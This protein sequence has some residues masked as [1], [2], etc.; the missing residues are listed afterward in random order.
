MNS[1]ASEAN[2][3]KDELGIWRV[4]MPHVRKNHSASVCAAVLLT[5]VNGWSQNQGGA[6]N[7]PSTS[8][9][10]AQVSAQASV[11]KQSITIVG[12]ND[13]N[14]ALSVVAPAGAPL[15]LVLLVKEPPAGHSSGEL[16]TMPFASQG[17][18][19]PAIARAK[20]RTSGSQESGEWVEVPLDKPGKIAFSLEFDRLRSGKTYKGQIFLTSGNLV[21]HWD[22]TVTT[23]GRGI[24]AVD[25]LGTL[26][27][28]TCL[29]SSQIGSFSFTL[30]DKSEG[31]P[32][33]HVH[34]RFEPSA[35]ANSKA[36]TSNFTF[37][38]FSFWE[39]KT[40]I[41]L[42]QAQSGGEA[43]GGG[44]TLT[45]AR[46]FTAQIGPLSPGEY[47]G[48]LHFS[49]DGVADDA[50]DGKLSL[51]IQVR[52]PWGYPV[53]VLLLG[54]VIGWFSS[55]YVVGKRKARDM[56]RQVEDLRKRADYLARPSTP[57]GGWEFPSEA[58]SLG[59]ARIGVDLNRVKKLTAS[60]LQVLVH[61]GEI[62]QLRQA[63]EQRLEA[64]KSLHAVRLR[65]QRIADGR[66]AAQQGIGRLLRSATDLLDGPA[67]GTQEQASMATL[68]TGLE[69]WA[70]ADTFAATYK[71]AVLDR[72]RDNICP[73]KQEIDAVPPGPLS[74]QLQALFK[75]LP[76]EAA[77]GNQTAINELTDSDRRIAR[78]ALLWRE[79]R[80]EWISKLVDAYAA[81][82]AI[83]D[84]FDTVD[85]LVWEV[86]KKEKSQL[87]LE[88]DSV[89]QNNP[90]TYE[91]LEIYLACH[92]KGLDTRRLQYH[93][94]HVAWS[95]HPPK[96]TARTTA[97][98]D[99]TLVQYFPSKG[100][101]IIS[102]KLSWKGEEIPVEP[103]MRFKV[104]ENPDYKFAIFTDVWTELAVIGVAALFAIVTAMGTQYDSTFGSL[105]QYIGLF[106]WA[107][108]AGTGGNLFN[109]LGTTSAPGGAAATLR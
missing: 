36:L 28:I 15:S 5:I 94:L 81:D 108:G 18:Q 26:K 68:L 91:V 14:D 75:L 50:A 40:R 69:S 66:P 11:L 93:P 7:E 88:R 57:R 80:Q 2:D 48:V 79:H 62:E 33:S 8:P 32:Y 43:A 49:A 64:F 27:F 46:T 47:S 35:T 74:T 85:A 29:L 13:N 86:I 99:L 92:I 34:V 23:G 41:D 6:P 98:D 78:I 90:R 105:A 83:G 101:A 42:E 61:E 96:G 10:P 109:Q 53:F 19:S 1:S 70:N 31:G 67:Y 72:R 45:S 102:A 77:I 12:A 95:I 58:I 63:T 97:T 3:S 106:I 73:Q 56:S 16:G 107:A 21:H 103:Y 87:K 76:D 65:V 51:L 9:A 59:F 89:G 37:D 39:N 55:K 25:P 82:N 71:K 22:V 104:V 17:E 52:H 20:L 84:L 24:L 60:P 30:F 4:L 54:S 44:V 100:K 38:T